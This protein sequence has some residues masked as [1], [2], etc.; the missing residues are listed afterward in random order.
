MKSHTLS[1]EQ[2]QEIRIAI[3]KGADAE[4]VAYEYNISR[5]LV[6]MTANLPRTTQH[7]YATIKPIVI[8]RVSS[9]EAANKISAE[10]GIP[11][12]TIYRWCHNLRLSDKYKKKS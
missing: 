7:K 2:E 10:L 9:G 11:V 8:D 4:D 3:R 1:K 12:R 6:Y 5:S